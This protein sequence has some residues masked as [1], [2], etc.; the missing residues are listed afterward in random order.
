MSPADP[1]MLATL[2]A[3]HRPPAA[4]KSSWIVRRAIRI[5]AK[6]WEIFPQA[7]THFISANYNLDRTLGGSK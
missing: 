5:A 3:I 7:F 4:W 2:D 1:R 6:P